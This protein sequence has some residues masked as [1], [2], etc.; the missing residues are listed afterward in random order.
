MQPFQL[1]SRFY[2][3]FDHLW[4]IEMDT[5]FLGHTG[6]M[7]NAYQAFGKKEPYKQARERAS[8]TFMP[9]VHGNYRKFSNGINRALQSNATTWGPPDTRIP[10]F[11]PLGPTPPV[12]DATLDHFEWLKGEEADLLLLAPAFDPARV[13][14]QPDWLFKNWIMGFD[15][16]LPR[17]ASFPAQARASRELLAAA[18]IGQRDLGLR[19]AGEATLPSF[20]LWHGFKIVQPPIPK[21]TFPERDLHELNEIYNGGM[22]NA[23]HDGI[24]RGKDP[25]RANALRWYSRPR[26]WEWGSSLV[27]PVWMHWRNWG[28]KKKRAWADVFGPVPNELP[29]FLRRIDGEVY[30]PNLMLHPHKTNGKPVGGG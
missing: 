14:T 29:A 5:R 30:A 28:P 6:K 18:H 10:G 22:P 13:Q 9:R 19:L 25:Y 27:E 20:A 2:P 1:F 11:K 21:F 7:L 16:S 24:A 15:R 8:W 26:T 12:A 23:F 17:L 3:E 4:Q